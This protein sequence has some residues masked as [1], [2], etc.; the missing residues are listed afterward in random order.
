MPLITPTQVTVLSDTTM[1]VGTII[2]MDLIGEIREQINLLTNNYFTSELYVQNTMTFNKTARTIISGDS[3][4]EFGFAAADEIYIANSYRN[5]GYYTVAS[6][7]GETL[8][9]ASGDSVISELSGRSVLISVVQ[10]PRA[11]KK[12][13][14]L[15]ISYDWDIRKR[16]A[17]GLTSRTL[18]P[19][20]EH[21]AL[22]G[23][24]D[25]GSAYP[26]EITD[27]LIPYR[28]ARLS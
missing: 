16:N 5:D 27:L 25:N 1:T 24:V 17:K 9:L 12:A 4:E 21:Y 15:M 2:A 28:V 3:F 10:W 26:K 11:I 7:V 22:G 14:A 18:G 13:A 19:L 6:V 8:T 20:T 23:S